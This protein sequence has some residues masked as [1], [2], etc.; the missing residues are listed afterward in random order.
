MTLVPVPQWWGGPTGWLKKVDIEVVPDTK[1]ELHGYLGGRFDLI[2]LG[3]YGPRSDGMTLGKILAAD[4]HHAREVHTFPYGRTDWIGFNAKTG[5]FAGVQGIWGRRALSLA[6][7]RTRLARAVC[8]GGLLC[9]A[10]TGGMISKGLSGYLG[11]GSDPMSAFDPKSANADLQAWDPE[12]TK[13]QGLTYVYVAN[14]VFHQVANNLRD[15]WKANLGI[16]VQLVGYDTHTFLSDRLLGDYTMFR[17]SWAVDYNSPQD[18]YDLFVGDPNPTGSG[19]ADPSFFAILARADASSGDEADGEYRQAGRRVLDQAV[20]APLI[21]FTR[22]AVVKVYVE[23]FGANA[24][25]AYPL[26]DLKIL[27]H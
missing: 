12:G 24:F 4:P 7:D 15:Q 10:A 9:V 1:A 2:G 13:R 21:Y 6:I 23:G 17:G 11:D 3:G 22:T 16:T 5:P 25:Y 19:F 14:S 27:Q 8:A 26:K 20:V 18:W